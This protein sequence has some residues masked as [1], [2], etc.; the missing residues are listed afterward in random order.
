LRREFIAEDTTGR[1]LVLS[2]W[3]SQYSKVVGRGEADGGSQ[4]KRSRSGVA[5]E[6]EWQ[7]EERAWAVAMG[8]INKNGDSSSLHAVSRCGEK[9][10]RQV[11]QGSWDT[12]RLSCSL[13]ADLFTRGG[14]CFLLCASSGQVA[15]PLL[16]YHHGPRNSES[17]RQ[18]MHLHVHMTL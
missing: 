3:G 11:K 13:A 12:F 15:C 1:G 2:L 8:E 14:L 4:E 17:S 18:D 10:E 5:E 9:L 7:M 16:A 6:G